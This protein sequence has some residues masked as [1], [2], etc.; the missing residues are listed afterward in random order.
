MRK[1]ERAKLAKPKYKTVWITPRAC[2]L[3]RLAASLCDHFV[4]ESVA[5]EDGPEGLVAVRIDA[6]VYR[7]A[8][9]V[10]HYRGESVGKWIETVVTELSAEAIRRM[11]GDG[12]FGTDPRDN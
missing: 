11:L 1:G 5:D 12:E 7:I 6:T 3:A 4:E 9:A 10:A 2:R 8:R